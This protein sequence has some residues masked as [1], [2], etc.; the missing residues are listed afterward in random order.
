MTHKKYTDDVEIE[1]KGFCQTEYTKYKQNNTPPCLD[2]FL[3]ASAFYD[4]FDNWFEG[5]VNYIRLMGDEFW[6]EYGFYVVD[7]NVPPNEPIVCRPI[8]E[9]LT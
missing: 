9:K 7:W 8:A 1:W 3:S 5:Y 4:A 2:F 6:A